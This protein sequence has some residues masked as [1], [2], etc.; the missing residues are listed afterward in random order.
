MQTTSCARKHVPVA[1][2][3]HEERRLAVVAGVDPRTARRWW[4]G[5][6]VTS[7]CAARLEEAAVELG[8]PHSVKTGTR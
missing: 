4:K 3:P 2:T 7:T 6:S 1:L 5:Q 8:L